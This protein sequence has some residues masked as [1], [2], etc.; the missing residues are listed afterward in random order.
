[1][2]RILLSLIFVGTLLGCAHSEHRERYTEPAVVASPPKPIAS[3]ATFRV[4]L[5]GGE[6]AVYP[7]KDGLTL[8][9]VK[10][11]MV[12]TGALS[13]DHPWYAARKHVRI[14]HRDGKVEVYNVIK[15]L[16]G[17]QKEPVISPGDII[18]YL[19]PAAW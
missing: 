4:R 5:E 8:S 12:G 3:N 17:E 6:I 15:I 13:L 14:A 1:M 7:W 9:G 11:I 10:S 2:T 19:G 18:E 16:K